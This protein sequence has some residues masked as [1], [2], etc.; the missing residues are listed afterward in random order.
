MAI[1]VHLI[2]AGT[3]TDDDN[4][5][6]SVQEFFDS[7]AWTAIVR[8]F[9]FLIVVLWLSLAFWVYKDAKRR[10][11]DPVLV[12]VAVATALVFP[13]IGALVYTILRPPEYMDD[14]RERELEIRAMERRLGGPPLPVLPH[15]GRVELPRLPALHEPAQDRLPSLQE[16]ARA[17]L[18]HVPALRDRGHAGPRGPRDLGRQ[19]CQAPPSADGRHQ[20]RVR[21]RHPSAHSVPGIPP[22]QRQGAWHR[23]LRHCRT[24]ASHGTRDHARPDQA[25]C[26]RA[27]PRRRAPRALR[28]ARLSHPRPAPDGARARAR[29]DPLRRA[30][31]APV[32]RRARRLHHLRAARR[33]RARGSKAR[34]RPC[35]R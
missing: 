30:L 1:P 35:A 31:G 25:R 26:R 9:L 19:W 27:R 29:R 33:D 23:Q 17:R 2:F 34:S 18:A 13:F 14:V 3:N 6:D 21:C 7:S 8:L 24:L 16:P 4:P 20:K 12:A 28:A 10:I 5:L 15:G 22:A 11:A 32:L